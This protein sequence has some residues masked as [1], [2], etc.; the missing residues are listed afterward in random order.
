MS[1]E[2][3]NFD[4]NPAD[5]DALYEDFDLEDPYEGEDEYPFVTEIDEWPD[6][7]IEYKFDFDDSEDC[8]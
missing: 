7:E 4:R 2:T 5:V 1:I 6:W 8:E 3:Q